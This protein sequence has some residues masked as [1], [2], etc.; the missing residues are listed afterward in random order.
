MKY[1]SFLK[2]SCA[3]HMDVFE[4]PETRFFFNNNIKV[5]V[6]ISSSREWQRYGGRYGGLELLH[7]LELI[8]TLALFLLGL[9]VVE[10]VGQG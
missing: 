7:A 1:A 8:L 6:M 10:V 2:P 9:V 3:L 4:Q 5:A